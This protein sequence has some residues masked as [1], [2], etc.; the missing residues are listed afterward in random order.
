M[1]V[2][3][4]NIAAP[5]GNFDKETRLWDFEGVTK[6]KPLEMF[7]HELVIA[8]EKRNDLVSS[9]TINRLTGKYMKMELKADVS[10]KCE[11]GAGY[12]ENGY[13]KQGNATLYTRMGPVKCAYYNLECKAGQ[14]T[15]HF[16]EQAKK[17][18]IFFSSHMTC[19]GDEIG[20]DFI[21][22]VKKSKISF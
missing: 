6:H 7:H 22:L 12:E 4:A 1:N 18:A 5:S 10:Q 17:E 16:T 21:S 15:V 19:C 20:W 13:K 14:C 8:T 3:D 11:C 2:D 9:K